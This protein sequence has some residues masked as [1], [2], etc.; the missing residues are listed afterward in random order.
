[1][2]LLS[3]REIE[4]ES[5]KIIAREAGSH[6]F[7]GDEWDVVRRVIH[8]TADFEF[9]K[10]IRIHSKAIDSGLKAI[11]GGLPIYTDTK[12]LSSAVNKA[13]QEKWG[14]RIL[15][16]IADEDVRNESETT[17]ATRSTIAMRKAAPL[18]KGGVIAIGNAPTALHEAISLCEQN[19]ITPDLIIGMPV[20]FVEAL[21]S[22]ERLCRSACC[23]ITN[24]D[25]KGGTAATAAV[26]N[27]LIKLAEVKS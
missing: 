16:F 24:L 12:M 4:E 27:A 1:M 7:A 26:I 2:K 11:K 20:G 5:M 14:C 3:P 10:T 9:M 25:I 6:Q 15:C 13:V 19:V 23:Y 18:L 21:E 22:K 17:G 8:A